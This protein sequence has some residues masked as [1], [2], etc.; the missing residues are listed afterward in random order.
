VSECRRSSEKGC[1]ERERERERE[2]LRGGVGFRRR[3]KALLVAA[4]EFP[5]FAT[6]FLETLE[7][8]TARIVEVGLRL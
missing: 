3:R 2:R 7:A 6:C 4:G 1:G 8:E 5:D